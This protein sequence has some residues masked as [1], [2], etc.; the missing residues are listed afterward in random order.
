MTPL[1]DDGI[2]EVF[3]LMGPSGSGKTTL[4]NVLAGRQ[5]TSKDK[6][7]GAVLVNG[8]QV[9]VKTFQQ[10][11]SFV[12][13][14]DSLIGSLLVQETLDFAARLALPRYELI[15]DTL[16]AIVSDKRTVQY[17]QGTAS[18]VQNHSSRASVS[19]TSATVS[20]VHLSAKASL[21]VKSGASVWPVNSSPHPRYCS[22]TNQRVVWIQQQAMK[23][24]SSS[25]TMHGSI[26]YDSILL[27]LS[28]RH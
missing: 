27:L 22:W 15:Y 16:C 6:T 5:A 14:E 8:R 19:K 28:G 21:E 20:S 25:K 11:S 23:L 10:L 18:Y 24:F 3:A 13:Q 4:L 1:T 17:P 26:V 9:P 2:G 7:E 12:E